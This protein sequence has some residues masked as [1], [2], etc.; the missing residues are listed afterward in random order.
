MQKIAVES[1][2]LIDGSRSKV[3]GT[4]KIASAGGRERVKKTSSAY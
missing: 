3:E 4:R 2:Q 1:G